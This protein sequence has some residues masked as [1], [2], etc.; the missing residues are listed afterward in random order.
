MS[1][2]ADAKFETRKVGLGAVI[3]ELQLRV[4]LPAVRSTVAS[5]ARKTRIDGNAIYEQYPKTYAAT[6]MFENLKFAMR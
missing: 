4:P 2:T 6:S 1:Q 5:G 3:E